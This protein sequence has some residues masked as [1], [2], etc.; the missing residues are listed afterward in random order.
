[1]DVP[2]CLSCVGSCL[3]LGNA[4]WAPHN[5]QRV[6]GGSCL[7]T[8][9]QPFGATELFNEFSHR[10]GSI[11][12]LPKA[13]NLLPSF[14]DRC[15]DRFCVYIQTQISCILAHERLLLCGSASQFLC[16]D[17]AYPTPKARFGR[18]IMTTRWPNCSRFGVRVPAST[19]PLS[20]QWTS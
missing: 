16:R 18:S 11:G 3:G 13:S 19:R 14:G 5:G 15:R 9:L 8:D 7:V 2:R 1:M 12:K 10:F 17:R 6:A 4:G 20:P